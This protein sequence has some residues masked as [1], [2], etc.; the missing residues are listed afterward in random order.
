MLS[1]S[2][3]DLSS[4]GRA[5]ALQARGDR[6][7]SDRLHHKKISRLVNVVKLGKRYLLERHISTQ[8]EGLTMKIL[9]YAGQQVEYA[10]RESPLLPQIACAGVRVGNRR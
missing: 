9:L 4:S 7:E 10:K 2:I 5:L 6:F 1:D 8:A 3:W